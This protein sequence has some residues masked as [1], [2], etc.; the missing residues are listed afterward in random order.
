VPNQT[1]G[2][3]KPAQIPH[4]GVNYTWQDMLN[5]LSRTNNGTDDVAGN[6]SLAKRISPGI[7]QTLLTV[8][9][10]AIK[11]FGDPSLPAANDFDAIFEWLLLP[12]NSL[13][14]AMWTLNFHLHRSD[15][16]TGYDPVKQRIA[17]GAGGL[18]L[19]GGAEFG[20]RGSDHIT[21]GLP[22]SNAWAQ[23]YNATVAHF[24]RNVG[25]ADFPQPAVRLNSV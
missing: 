1:P 4:N 13:R 16:P 20:Y 11:S 17:Y 22:N 3:W 19:S 18:Y 8:A 10:S 5:D 7:A 25:T 6:T 9:N 23:A 21:N 24:N 12:E 15:M 14:A 2:L